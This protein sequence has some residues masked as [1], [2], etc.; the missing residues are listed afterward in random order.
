M[1]GRAMSEL[2]TS[3]PRLRIGRFALTLFWWLEHDRSRPS[4][5]AR[6]NY[7]RGLMGLPPLRVNRGDEREAGK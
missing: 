7:L 5:I 4:A 6:E 1:T 3:P 2:D